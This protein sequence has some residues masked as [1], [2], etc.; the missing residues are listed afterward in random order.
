MNL[1]EEIVCQLSESDINKW[2]GIIDKKII[3]RS[4]D[5]SDIY[6]NDEIKKTKQPVIIKIPPSSSL[7]Y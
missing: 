6:S 4:Y 2:I 7:L 3:I 5:L 1:S